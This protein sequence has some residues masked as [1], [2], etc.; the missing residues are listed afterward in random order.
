MKYRRRNNAKPNRRAESNEGKQTEKQPEKTTE[1]D[2]TQNPP[3]PKL[4][5]TLLRAGR[6]TNQ[7]RYEP[8]KTVYPVAK[9]MRLTGIVK[10]EV[11]VNES[12]EVTEVQ[13]TT[14]PS[15]LQRAATD[16]VRRWKFK[17]FMRDGQP[18]KASG[19]VSFNF[20]L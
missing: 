1:N 14:G 7:L 10:V 17:P 20:S 5:I 8:A 2:E 4:R 18:V 6:F 3:K 15:M 13:T 19:F 11:L 12:G 9:N 16:A